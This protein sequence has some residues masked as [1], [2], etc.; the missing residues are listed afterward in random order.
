MSTEPETKPA[1]PAALAERPSKAHVG[2]GSM[3]TS[4]EAAY[5][6][7]QAIAPAESVPKAFRGK[8]AD[9]LVA[10]QFGAELN[11]LPMQALQSIA[12]VNGMP[13]LWGDG[14]LAVIMSSP[15]YADHDEWYEV[16]GE[17][18]DGLL[19]EDLKHD[20]TAAVCSMTRRGKEPKTRRFT[21]AQAKKAQLLTKEGPWQTHPDRML[22]MRARMFAARDIFP[23]VLRGMISAEEAQDTGAEV[24]DTQPVAPRRLSESR[25]TDSPELPD[26]AATDAPPTDHPAPTA[27]PAS[28]PTVTGLIT[29]TVFVRPQQGEPFY[30]VTLHGSDGQ[31][32]QLVTRDELVYREARSFEG[33]DHVV[34]LEYHDAPRADRSE[35]VRVIDTLALYEGTPLFG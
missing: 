19:V 33:T 6:F 11:L 16:K 20:D 31:D 13:R 21:I 29:K 12:V 25:V 27:V 8:P 28:K 17:R 3:F 10:I 26:P 35:R 5:R 30:Q 22:A 9:I 14:L 4:I 15:V 18:R 7:A 2:I 34:S 24:I 1:E 23:D 32:H